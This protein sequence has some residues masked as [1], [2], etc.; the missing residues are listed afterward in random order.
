MIY[1]PNQ[2]VN[3]TVLLQGF[4]LSLLLQQADPLPRLHET[5]S[6][7]RCAHHNQ[8]RR[9]HHKVL[10]YLGRQDRVVRA[11]SG[12]HH[13][14]AP[15]HGNRETWQFSNRGYPRVSLRRAVWDKSSPETQQRLSCP[16]PLPGELMLPYVSAKQDIR[17]NQG[18]QMCVSYRLRAE[19]ELYHWVRRW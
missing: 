14:Q 15:Y 6:P 11:W 19:D 12:R 16:E 2:K 3:I 1:D 4:Q 9:H 8:T 7:D 13:V 5:E 18:L 10:R 17:G